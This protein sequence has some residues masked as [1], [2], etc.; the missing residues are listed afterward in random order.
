MIYIFKK[1]QEI[2]QDVYKNMENFA[3]KS[4]LQNNN[5]MDIPVSGIKNLRDS[6][7]PGGR[8]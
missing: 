8:Q 4:K 7:T 5:E 2:S 3:I 6:L 1:I